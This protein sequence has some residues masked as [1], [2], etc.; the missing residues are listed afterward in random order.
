MTS[1][2]NASKACGAPWTASDGREKVNVQSRLAAAVRGAR[3]GLL[4]QLDS[5]IRWRS[6]TAAA[7]AGSSGFFCSCG[8]S[9]HQYRCFRARRG[10]SGDPRRLEDTCRDLL[11]WLVESG[12]RNMMHGGTTHNPTA[13]LPRAQQGGFWEWIF[14]KTHQQKTANSPTNDRAGAW[15]PRGSP[16]TSAAV[17]CC[18]R[19][20]GCDSASCLVGDLTG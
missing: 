19:V 4:H 9:A 3:V 1:G 6:T 2:S 15:P 8:S 18:S 11:L 5:G 16:Q 12:Q 14:K 20:A 13:R 7:A 17:L 10:F